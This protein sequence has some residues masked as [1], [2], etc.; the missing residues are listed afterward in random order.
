LTQCRLSD[1]DG[2]RGPREAATLHDFAKI[3]EL[4]KTHLKRA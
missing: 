1:M 2:R 3:P 4:A